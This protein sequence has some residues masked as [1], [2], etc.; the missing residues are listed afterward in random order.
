VAPEVDG[1]PIRTSARTPLVYVAGLVGPI[2]GAFVVFYLGSV[3][4]SG[5]SSSGGG[6]R[7]GLWIMV[8]V[9]VLVVVR[10]LFGALG[11]WFR[12]YAVG[13]TQLV[14]DEGVF[15]RRRRVVPFDRV[16]QVDTHQNLV[17]QLFNVSELRVAT[18]IASGTENVRLS[19]LDT[20]VAT[21]LR[22]YIVDRRT[23]LQHAGAATR[24]EPSSAETA[25]LSTPAAAPTVLLALS[26]AR[27]ALASITH[28]SLLVGAVG[29]LVIGLWASAGAALSVSRFGLAVLLGGGLL[30]A[31]AVATLSGL[32][33][34]TRNL[35]ERYG[36]TLR[37]RGDDLELRMGLLET[38]TI[39]VPRRR[40]QQ[41]S[42]VDNPVR[43][44]LGLV[45]LELHT[46]SAG[47]EKTQ[48]EVPLVARR[49]L[50]ELLVQ[51]MGDRS[52][53]PP[54]I[55]ARSDRARSRAIRRR[56]IVTALLL[57]P[58]AIVLRPFGYLLFLAAAIGIPWGR[59]AHRRAGHGR[60]A[61]LIGLSHGVLHHRTELVPLARVQ[62]SRT[63]SSPFQRHAGLATL[64]VD[65]AGQHVAL[66]GIDT[67]PHLFD[68]DAT[69]ADDLRR[70]L[71]RA[72]T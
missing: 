47:G 52:W 39:T 48:F 69:T 24:P 1:P 27:L 38:R 37:A 40:V 51:I 65:V 12:T 54:P 68:L 22:T 29:G 19:F 62:S 18:A 16:Q 59:V 60:S 21:G 43:R 34:V 58:P 67:S 63:H 14:I 17:A 57:A 2:F 53:L 3:G 35:L 15:T 36:F 31:A 13:P 28:S 72:A 49:D 23:A 44:A 33:V 46:A 55:T 9:I 70:T 71:P 11:W 30:A 61:T 41:V 10:V 5:D 7:T 8:A 42:I 50:D 56:V 66:F 32:M 25:D 64:A 45:A 6:N 26:P 20:P 4:D